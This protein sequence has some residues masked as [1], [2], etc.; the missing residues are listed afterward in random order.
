[1]PRGVIAKN[2]YIV[3]GL[4]R[5][6]EGGYECREWDGVSTVDEIKSLHPE[7]E[8][9]GTHGLQRLIH[10]RVD[11]VLKTKKVKQTR[12]YIEKLE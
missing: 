11:G 6:E 4:F 3:R 8:E 1:M 9:L 10:R 12:Y 7:L 5:T 2:R